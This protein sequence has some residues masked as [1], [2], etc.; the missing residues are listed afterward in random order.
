MTMKDH[1]YMVGEAW[2]DVKAEST[3]VSRRFGEKPC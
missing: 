2:E 3:C 1:A